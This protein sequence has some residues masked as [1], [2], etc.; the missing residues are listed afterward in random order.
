MTEALASGN[1]IAT[2]KR[3]SIQAQQICN[4]PVRAVLRA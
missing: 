1:L 4:P 2:A 3:H